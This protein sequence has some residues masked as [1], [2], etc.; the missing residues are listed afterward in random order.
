VIEVTDY[1]FLFSL[2]LSMTYWMFRK[3]PFLI[4]K[5]S[6]KI[7]VFVISLP[8]LIIVFMYLKFNVDKMEKIFYKL[9]GFNSGDILR[10]TIG[11]LIFAFMIV[12]FNCYLMI[13]YFIII[14]SL[15]RFDIW[16]TKRDI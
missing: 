13:G 5:N 3:Y 9:F 4:L 2:Y 12:Y 10:I 16:L 8:F 1:C 15:F 7:P 6:I 11:M 14:E